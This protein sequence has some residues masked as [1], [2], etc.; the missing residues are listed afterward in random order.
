MSF[1]VIPARDSSQDIRVLKK[2]FTSNHSSLQH[3]IS[4][5][6]FAHVSSLFLR[7][8]NRVL[9]LKSATQQKN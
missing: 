6:D 3:E 1:K 2:E 4:F 7:I 8:N 9:A 5:I